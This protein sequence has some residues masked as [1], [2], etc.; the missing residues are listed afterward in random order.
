MINQIHTLDCFSLFDQL[1]DRT[2]DLA[3]CDPPY[4]YTTRAG[5]WDKFE[6]R[7]K[8]LKWTYEWIDRMLPKLKLGASVYIF[9]TPR[10]SAYILAHLEKRGFA[11]RNWITWYKPDSFVN[12]CMSFATA[13][14]SVL[15]FSNGEPKTFNQD[16]VRVPYEGT[17]RKQRQSIQ[18][19]RGSER[20]KYNPLGAQCTDVWK[21]SGERRSCQARGRFQKLAH[22]TPKPLEMIQRMVKASSNKGDI[23]L[24]PFVGSGTTAVAAKSLGRRFICSDENRDYTTLAKNRLRLLDKGIRNWNDH[25]INN[26]QNPLP[27]D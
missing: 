17:N 2:I 23:V 6:S 1:R 11:F 7:D 27:F 25:E 18:G 10:N 14:E 5:E 22:P 16:D 3:I 8:F 19:K 9:N 15:L 20:W 12:A 21:Y 4:N 26:P 24:D 13:Q